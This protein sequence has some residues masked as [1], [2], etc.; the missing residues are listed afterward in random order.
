MGLLET[1]AAP[2]TFT[3][4]SV[5]HLGT[6]IL[7]TN[8]SGTSLWSG[9][10]EP[11]GRDWNGAQTAGEFL[12]FPGQWDDAAW[13]GG[14]GSGL[15]YNVHR[16]YSPALGRYTQPDPLQ[17]AETSRVFFYPRPLSNQRFSLFS[18]VDAAPLSFADPLGLLKFVGCSQE[19]QQKLN[20]GLRDYCSKLDNPDFGKCCG[21]PAIT[22]GIKR[23]CSDTNLV[24]QCESRAEGFCEAGHTAH[25]RR[26]SCGW[27]LP[28]VPTIHF[29]PDG[30]TPTCGPTGCTLLH[31]MTH[32]AG[33]PFE[34]WPN[35]VE[36][37][38]ECP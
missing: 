11:F 7:E 14:A 32:I 5:D 19:Q 3:Y 22:H 34:K 28:F 36:E 25:G 30:W 23:L 26:V 20:D 6:P 15:Y 16:W 18:Y 31:E 35:R 37:C 12:R 21:R 24:V 38:L 29:C 4:L 9:G 13:E 10:F 2:A 8:A 1:T 17:I 27:S 33:H